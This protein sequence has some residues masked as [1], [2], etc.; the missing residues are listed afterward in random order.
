MSKAVPSPPGMATR[1]LRSFGVLPQI[2]VAIDRFMPAK[3]FTFICGSDDFLVGRMGKDRFE[4]MAQEVDDEFS[5]DV[6]NGFAANVG[7]VEAAVN[8]F[9]DAVQTISMFGGKRAV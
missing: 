9:R 7:E 3:A 1:D 8:R 2:E 4:A 6:L 5:R